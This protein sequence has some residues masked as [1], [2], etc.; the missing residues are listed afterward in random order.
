MMQ[1]ELA[2]LFHD[3]RAPVARAQT[4]GKLL[5]G[6]SPAELAELLPQLNRALQDITVL[7]D[8]AEDRI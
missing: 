6:A 7:L 4:Y 5:E 2:R 1:D 3:L 8:S